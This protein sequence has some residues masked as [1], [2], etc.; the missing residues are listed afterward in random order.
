M[1]IMTLLMTS[2]ALFG[3]ENNEENKNNHQNQQQ[4]LY[5]GI[6]TFDDGELTAAC[7][8]W[9]DVN[10]MEGQWVSLRKTFTLDEKPTKAIA[11]ISADTKYWMWI[12]GE[13]A[14]FEGQLK[15]GNS[16][17]TW[18]Y[19]EE[20]LT[21]YFV[22]GENTIAVQV[23][24]SGKTSGSTV[25]TGVPGFLFDAKVDGHRIVSDDTWK[26]MLDP[27]YENP[28]SLNNIRNGE[29]NIKY[30]GAFTL[31]DDNGYTWTEKGFDD[32]DWEDA[33]V[34]DEKIL[35]NRVRDERSG[36]FSKVYY[37]N[38]DPRL[39][40]VRRSIP[41]LKLDEIT[42]YT[43]NGANGTKTWTKANDDSNFLPL[44]L[45][46]TYTVVAEVSVGEPLEYTSNQ[47]TG[48]A[49]GLC[50]CVSDSNNFYMPQIS[51]NQS[52]IFDGVRFNPHIKRSGNWNVTS[53]ELT[54]TE[55][56]KS[57]YNK[58]VYDNRYNTT[59]SIK[60][61]VTPETIS[62]YLNNYL[63]GT[64]NDT[65]LPRTGS[66]IGFRQDINELV[67]IYSLKVLDKNGN[68]LYNVNIS[69]CEEGNMISRISLLSSENP[70][71]NSSYNVV[72]TDD[73]G[74]EYV[75][76]RNSC[77]AINDGYGSVKYKIVNET[78]IQ[79]TPYLKVRSNKGGE[80]ISIKSDSWVNLNSGGTSI[81][82]QYITCKGEQEWEALGWM[83]GYE[84]TFTIPSSVQVLELGFRK[85][86]YN[87]TATGMVTTDNQVLNQLYQEAY[88]TLYVCMRDSYMDCPDRERT[89]WWGDA[90]IN[91][92]QAAYALDEQG[93]LLYKKTLTQAVGFMLPNGAIPS[94]VALGNDNLELPMQSLAG[95]HSFWQYYM[96]Y[97]DK[98]LVVDAYPTLINYLKLWNISDIGVITHRSG[99]WDWI[100]WGEHYDTTVIE[101]CWYYIALNAVL[102]IANL[103][104]SGAS[105]SDKTFLANK[106]ELI[107]ENFDKNYWD[108]SKNAYY[109]YT[110]NGVADDRANALAI[111][112]G[113][114]SEDKYAGI[115]NVLVNTYNASPYM[116]KYVLEAMY[117]INAD[118]EAVTRTL[119][120]F[121]PFTLDGYPT[122][123]E[124]WADQTLFGGDETKNH[125]WTGAP[126]SLLYMYNAGI[127]STS[128]GF[129][130]IQIKPHLGT[131]NNVDAKVE[132]ASGKIV[133]DI[134]K[135]N[136]R[137]SLN[138][139][140]PQGADYAVV[141]VPKY[142]DNATI[143]LNDITIYSNHSSNNLP[144]GV[145]YLEE[146]SYYVA[147]KV[148]SGTY[149]FI[150]K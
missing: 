13:L 90:V 146:D 19:D 10:V 87:A 49:I 66:T 108:N 34:Q 54:N 112:A 147:F 119:N 72:M 105:D 45:P 64:I 40:L 99:T 63:L 71:Y 86:G 6:S 46:D 55:V 123:P 149:N 113:L 47:P 26:A 98:E 29:A 103:E 130:T 118:N 135:N 136:N 21:D 134:A 89:Q 88:D 75:S 139:T 62:T 111:Y 96:Y 107:K 102:N 84:I 4:P 80:L 76:V 83:N 20:D 2:F 121:T 30:N 110:D 16:I 67:N 57:L 81:A 11:R 68:E 17:E 82:H 79:G 148:E 73:K 22:E 59:H 37:K 25:N 44:N 28:T 77:A 85:S 138:V 132:R 58:G 3:C 116:E 94:M 101:N 109:S 8:I 24:Y 100:D 23:F 60:I 145:S 14:I 122:L 9:A 144:N 124:I 91:M 92:Q 36:G 1:I 141:Y 15:L 126:L 50:V 142:T 120:R 43:A 106:M 41:Q 56:G 93:A 39:N 128:A 42:K 97:G 32:S 150:S 131:L 48:A 7:W 5:E 129:K 12:N 18:F 69:E 38:V 51:F 61:E 52:N 104:G 74:N 114:A 95:V 137:Y 133:V 35:V 143:E 127:T 115:L 78:N 31:T 70:S 27:A 53:Q 140:I 65:S 33:I 117:M 125:A